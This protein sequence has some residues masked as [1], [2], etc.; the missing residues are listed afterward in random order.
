M[1]RKQAALDARLF[2]AYGQ[3]ERLLNLH[4]EVLDDRDL[5]LFVVLHNDLVKYYRD[6]KER[7]GHLRG[8]CNCETDAADHQQTGGY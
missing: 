4:I 1:I 7:R 8:E 2:R 3:V 5:E 6:E